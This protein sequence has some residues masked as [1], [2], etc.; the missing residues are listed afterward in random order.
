MTSEVWKNIEKFPNYSVSD[1]G[2][3]KNIKTGNNLNPS[4]NLEG[5]E[6]VPLSASGKKEN[7]RVHRAVALAFLSNPENKPDVDHIDR[8]RHNNVLSNLRWATS[9]EQAQNRMRSPVDV[10]YRRSVWKCDKKT[11]ERLELFESTSLAAKAVY[12]S[13]KNK[14]PWN[15][16]SSAAKGC[17]P[18]AYGYTWE[19][20]YGEVIEGENWREIHPD[21]I[22]LSSGEKTN[23]HISDMGRLKGPDGFIKIPYTIELGYVC[24]GIEGRPFY[25]HRLVALTFL[26]QVPGKSLV[27]HI[28]GD[29]RNC[30][31]SNLEFV[32]HLENNIHA[33]DTGLNTQVI[34]ICQYDLSG[35][36]LK[37]YSSISQASKA[38]NVS[39]TS[40]SKDLK[41]GYT[42]AGFQWRV[43]NGSSEDIQAV[44]DSR[45][46][47]NVLQ[48]SLSGEFI[49]EYSNARDASRETGVSFTC[50]SRAA[51]GQGRVCAQCQWRTKYSDIQVIDLSK[52]RR[53]GKTPMKQ[54]SLDGNLVMEYPSISQASSKTGF[55][56][57]EISKHST[58]GTPYKGYIWKT[59]ETEQNKKRK[60]VD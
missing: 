51:R 35:K 29:K 36:L 45:S 21:A 58:T 3:I 9:K 33:R 42:T 7:I 38:V 47:N 23:Y 19:Y 15:A 8:V 30:N 13:N 59:V 31:V 55:N 16:I 17:V 56:R 22:G 5:Y 34:G 27:N 10:K 24:F 32:T 2:N 4:R 12:H 40:M 11:G 41:T 44:V 20:E 6:I 26:E 54:M 37:K 57:K 18:N 60:R 14:T 28:D 49:R 52:E 39:Q 53:K 43:D 48:Y 50:I 25:A 46:K 1:L